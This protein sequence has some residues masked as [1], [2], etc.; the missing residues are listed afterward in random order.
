MKIHKLVLGALSLIF[1]LFALTACGY[2][3]SAIGGIEQGLTVGSGADAVNPNSPIPPSS[4]GEQNDGIHYDTLVVSKVDALNVRSG[5]GTNFPSVGTL[6]K[7][8]MV[9][10]IA[11][12]DGWYKKVKPCLTTSVTGSERRLFTQNKLRL[13]FRFIVAFL[14]L[15]K[16]DFCGIV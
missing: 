16:S 11:T 1:A 8:D 2:A 10:Y 14:A 15:R 7:G 12:Q 5:K 3:N 6:D 4:D 9:S 13:F